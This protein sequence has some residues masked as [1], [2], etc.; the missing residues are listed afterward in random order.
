MQLVGSFSILLTGNEFKI[1][2]IMECVVLFGMVLPEPSRPSKLWMILTPPVHI[3][4]SLKCFMHTAFSSWDCLSG[5]HM[6]CNSLKYEKVMAYIRVK[7]SDLGIIYKAG[8][9][10]NSECHPPSRGCWAL[11]QLYRAWSFDKDLH[12][13]S[14]TVSFEYKFN[15]QWLG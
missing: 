3:Q 11:L 13:S 2:N 14:T 5:T 1:S 8:Y 9:A 7:C 4:L 10:H 12:Q 15:C 6:K